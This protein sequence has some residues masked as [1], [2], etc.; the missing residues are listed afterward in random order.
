MRDPHL[1]DGS[2]ATQD[3]DV[4][5]LEGHTNGTKLGSATNGIN[6]HIASYNQG[7]APGKYWGQTGMISG[8]VPMRNGLHNGHSATSSIHSTM[9]PR[10]VPPEDTI[11]ASPRL[12]PTPALL[13]A[14]SDFGPSR[15][16]SIQAESEPE[17]EGTSQIRH[18]W[19]NEYS[20][21]EYLSFLHSVC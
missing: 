18:G 6:G 21:S 15:K 17:E 13:R 20:S 16:H 8:S 11:Q 1:D 12:R 2:D 5:P 7:P 9:E 10:I 4:T 14:K 3:G 19:D